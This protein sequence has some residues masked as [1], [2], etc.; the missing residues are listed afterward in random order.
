MR[1]VLI[2]AGTYHLGW[3]FDLSSEAQDGV[4]RTVA[5][6][7]QSRQQ[8]LSECFSPERVVVLDAFEIQA[9]P[10]KHI[11]DFVPVQD[12]QRMV[13]Y[14]SMSEIIDNVLRSTGWRLPTE[15]EFEAAAGGTLFLWGD[16]VPLGKPRRENLHRGRGPNGLTLPHWDYQKELVNGAFKMGDGGCLGC[17]GASWP[18]TWLLMSPT[19]RVPANIINENWITFL[20]EA[21]VHP[22]RI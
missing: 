19:S 2:P 21:W 20:E 17:S 3:R 6:F 22:V 15:D 8:F 10:I 1:T 12:R 13:D 11:L 18:S 7:G 5:S 14:A 4:D 9:E 16:E